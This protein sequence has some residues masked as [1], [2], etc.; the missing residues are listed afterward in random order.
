MEETGKRQRRME[1][2]SE[3]RQ[4]PEGAVAPYL[5]WTDEKQLRTK[6]RRILSTRHPFARSVQRVR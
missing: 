4:G 2:S 6:N 1:T 3:G 5:E